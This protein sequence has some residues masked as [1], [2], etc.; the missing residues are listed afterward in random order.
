MIV[1]VTRNVI[2]RL[3]IRKYTKKEEGEV[4]NKLKTKQNRN[5]FSFSDKLSVFLEL[6]WVQRYR[7]S[8]TMR[9][10][11]NCYNV[12]CLSQN[13]TREQSCLSLSPSKKKKKRRRRRRRK[14]RLCLLPEVR[15]VCLECRF[16][17]VFIIT[18]KT[19]LKD[20]LG[21]ARKSCA[22]QLFSCVNVF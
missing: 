5:V 20:D 21:G 11:R 6:L 13:G 22:A 2:A 4:I 18:V 16:F 1:N 12:K 17:F 7:Q 8:Y 3:A 15:V 10:I 9:E 14:K 19:K